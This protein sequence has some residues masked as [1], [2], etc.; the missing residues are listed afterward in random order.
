MTTDPLAYQKRAIRTAIHKVPLC[1]CGSTETMWGI[2]RAVLERNVPTNEPHDPRPGC[3][4]PMPEFELS[5]YGVEFVA[6][7]LSETGF[8]AHG[9]GVGY[10]WLTG[11]GRLLLLFLRKYGTKGSGGLRDMGDTSQG[12]WPIW[13]DS[14]APTSDTFEITDEEWRKLSNDHGGYENDEEWKAV[15]IP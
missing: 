9:S 12:Y 14:C 3:Y 5:R 8:T 4:D 13:A 11:A 6:Q 7:V 15:V 10:G 1:G 2:V